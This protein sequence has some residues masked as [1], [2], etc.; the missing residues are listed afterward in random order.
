MCIYIILYICIYIYN[1][2][3]ICILLLLLEKKKKHDMNTFCHVGQEFP[4][5]PYINT[6]GTPNP[7]IP[8][9]CALSMR[10]LSKARSWWPLETEDP[11]SPPSVS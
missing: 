3:Y 4:L 10:S 9:T 8:R 11:P 5:H 2:I 7:H 6:L 1:Y